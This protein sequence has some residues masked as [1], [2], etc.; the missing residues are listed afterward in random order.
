M[1]KRFSFYFLPY[2]SLSQKPTKF[3]SLLHLVFL[4][5]L[6]QRHN[7][8][9]CILDNCKR[10]RNDKTMNTFL[11]S[12]VIIYH[13]ISWFLVRFIYLRQ[14]KLLQL[15]FVPKMIFQRQTRMRKTCYLFLFQCMNCFRVISIK[16]KFHLIINRSKAN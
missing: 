10:E 7:F 3:Q 8:P 11:F 15:P 13:E 1:A 4:S 6:T 9:N 12:N 14:M 5:A 16:S 2:A